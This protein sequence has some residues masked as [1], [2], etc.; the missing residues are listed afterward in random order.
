MSSVVAIQTISPWM[1][2]AIPTVVTENRLS[3]TK[4]NR[5]VREPRPTATRPVAPAS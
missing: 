5:H 2:L 1:V 4:G 3:F